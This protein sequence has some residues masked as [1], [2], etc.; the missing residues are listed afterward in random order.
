M[1]DDQFAPLTG[2]ILEAVA[3]LT[4]KPVQ[5]LVNTH[6][7]FDHT[8]GNENFGKE[9]AVIVAHENVRK[10]MSAEQVMEAFGQTVPPAPPDA[11]PVI[12]FTDSMTFHWND[13]EVKVVHVP[14]A[15]TDGDSFVHFVN[16]NVIHAGDL[17]FNGM[18]PFIDAEHG[19]SI[20]GMIAGTTRILRL[21]DDDTRII[22]GHGEVSGVREL[23]TYREMLRTVRDSIALQIKEGKSREEIIA[24]KPTAQFDEAWGGGFLQPDQWVGIV[25]DSMQNVPEEGAEEEANQ[26][27]GRTRMRQRND[28]ENAVNE[29]AGDGD[30]SHASW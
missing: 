19:G 5:F 6:W 27:A 25:F 13:D 1:I 29:N 28:D 2:K 8:G 23:R 10:L 24:A 30:S 26:G 12:T 15:H 22:P 7:H 16:D 20:D 17:Y 11:L 14:P 18:Y 3:T 4:D 21:A 9:G